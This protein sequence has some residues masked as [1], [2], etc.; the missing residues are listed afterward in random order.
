MSIASAPFSISQGSSNPGQLSGTQRKGFETQRKVTR[1]SG[2]RVFGWKQRFLMETFSSKTRIVLG[3]LGRLLRLGRE[4]RGQRLT[5]FHKTPSQRGPETW[6]GPQRGQRQGWDWSPGL[7]PALQAFPWMAFAFSILRTL[8]FLISMTEILPGYHSK[9]RIFQQMITCELLD[10]MDVDVP[11][12]LC[13]FL[14][15]RLCPLSH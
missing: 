6:P 3:K 7:Q 10:R 9:Q 4:P 15:G 5:L 14:S 8:A 13:D 12:E 11:W 2:R 1:T